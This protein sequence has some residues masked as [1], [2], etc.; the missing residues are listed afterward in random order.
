MVKKEYFSRLSDGREVYLYRISNSSGDYVDVLDYGVT[1]YRVMM[2]DRN[3]VPGDCVLGMPDPSAVETFPFSGS[4]VGR[5]ANRIAYGKCTVNGKKLE[6][7]CSQR[8]HYLHGGSGNYQHKLFAGVPD[9]AGNAVNVGYED[10][11]EGGFG[12]RVAVNVRVS[13][14]DYRRL[15]F[16]YTMTPEAD[17]L[18]NPTCHAYFNLGGKGESVLNHILTVNAAEYA[19]KGELEMPEGDIA[20]VGGTPL[21]FIKPHPLSASL[22]REDAAEFFGER[23]SIDDTFLLDKNGYGIAASLYDP[24]SGR[25]MRVYTDMPSLIVFTIGLKRPMPGKYGLIYEG[26]ASVCLE[27]QY[28]P[29]AVNCSNFDKPVFLAGESLH[30]RTVYAFDIE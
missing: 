22:C 16:E 19:V 28:V 25:K 5:C 11:G 23:I 1:L 18:L 14:D 4:V 13:L 2:P 30:S 10:T 17:T 12:D 9:E 15:M 20:G 7:E 27:T 29:N 3:G 21:D 26:Y 8:G 24:A 6:L